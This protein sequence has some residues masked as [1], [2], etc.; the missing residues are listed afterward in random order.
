MAGETLLL[1]GWTGLV[2]AD[3]A[4]ADNLVDLWTQ[5]RE[6]GGPERWSECYL[7]AIHPGGGQVP[8]Y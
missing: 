1:C 4:V 6:I 5:V 7:A 3:P 8:R 2:N